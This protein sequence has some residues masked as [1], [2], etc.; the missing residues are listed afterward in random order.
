MVSSGVVSVGTTVSLAMYCLMAG[1]SYTGIMTAY[2]D[3]QKC[4]GSLQKVL[5][6]LGSAQVEV[7][8]TLSD[9]IATAQPLAVRFQNVSFVYPARPQAYVLSGLN[10]DI[11]A[12]SRVAVLGRSGSGKSTI[13]LLLAGLYSPNTG[14]IFVDG[15]DMFSDATTAAW[16]RSQLGVISQ[17]PTL[18]AMSIRENVAWRH[19]SFANKHYI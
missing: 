2:G 5:D 1:S 16:V 3:I 12:G 10:L 13:A 17:E 9:S 11:P 7:R 8:A 15:H 18:F 6:I 19:I 4:L 14:K